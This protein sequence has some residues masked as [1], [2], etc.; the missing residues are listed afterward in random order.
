MSR[1]ISYQTN[2]EILPKSGV[3]ITYFPVRGWALSE[4]E[5][6][7]QSEATFNQ[8]GFHFDPVT[9]HFHFRFPQSFISPMRD[10]A[11]KYVIFQYCR[12]TYEGHFNSEIEIHANFIPRDQYC[13]SLV[14]YCNLQVPDDNRKY[15]VNS[16]RNTLFEVWFVDGSQPDPDDHQN[17]EF[18]K[19]IDNPEYD[20]SKP[21]DPFTNPKQIPKYHPKVIVPDTFV[22]FLKLIY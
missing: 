16:I 10:Q 12:A 21:E 9:K 3:G 22:L 11:N 6:A 2:P 19:M 13:D 5:I 17:E 15:Q 1:I 8:K 18:D 14:Y 20:D 7:N 4:T